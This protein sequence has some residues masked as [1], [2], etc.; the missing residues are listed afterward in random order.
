MSNAWF[1][2]WKASGSVVVRL[3]GTDS[4]S[5]AGI[6]SSAFAV[7]HRLWSK[8]IFAPK[9]MREAS[10]EDKILCSCRD[11]LLFLSTFY[12]IK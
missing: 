9:P 12:D 11:F 10:F 7:P 4:A 2:S 1:I 6:T 3:R 5:V 8:R